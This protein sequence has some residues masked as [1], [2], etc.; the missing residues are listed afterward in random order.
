MTEEIIKKW[1]SLG[2]YCTMLPCPRC[3]HVSMRAEL[4]H[5][6]LSRRTDLYVCPNCGTEESLE[7]YGVNKKKPLEEWFLFT[8]IYGSKAKAHEGT[9]GN[10]VLEVSRQIVVTR[11]DIDDIMCCAL[12]GGINYWCRKAEVVEGIYYGE[13]ASEQIS[14]G[15]SLRLY[16]SEEDEVYVLT[17]DKFLNGISLA[18]RDGYAD[19]W[20][21]GEILDC[22]QIDAEAADI[23]VQYALFGEVVYG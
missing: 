13:Y 21:D 18:C 1:K 23:I 5:N 8:D 15:G 7:D 2:E 17:L 14:H 10:F 9:R 22:C 16:D 4:G 3:G 12:E 6:A 20:F 11:Q 19:E